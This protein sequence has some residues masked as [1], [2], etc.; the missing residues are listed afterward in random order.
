MK[1]ILNNVAKAKILNENE[2]II[3][4]NRQK[5]IY[6][7]R[8]LERLAISSLLQRD[9][10]AIEQKTLSFKRLKDFDLTFCQSIIDNF[11]KIF[12]ASL[13]PKIFQKLEK[14]ICEKI[15]QCF[16]LFLIK[17]NRRLS[18]KPKKAL[19]TLDIKFRDIHYMIE[20]LL[21][22]FSNEK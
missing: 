5:L 2:I 3:N 18:K 8:D 10:N 9:I 11:N 20:K 19:R 4:F 15:I 13:P 22:N 16:F 6:G 12:Q 21:M 7:F 1:D 17:C 14:N